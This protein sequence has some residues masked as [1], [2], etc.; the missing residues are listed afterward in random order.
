MVRESEIKIINR[1]GAKGFGLLGILIAMAIIAILF[2]VMTGY[3]FKGTN[4]NNQG[5][6]QSPFNP[7]YEGPISPDSVQ[8]GIN[9]IN[10]AKN[11]KQTLENQAQKQ[12]DEIASS[13]KTK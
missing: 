4:T 11:L 8:S 9:A 2:V 6:Y 7:V 10:A 12:M 13:S 1:K 3:L 5:N